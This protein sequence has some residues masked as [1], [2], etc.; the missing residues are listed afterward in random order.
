M[1]K[2]GLCPVSDNK[3]ILQGLVLRIKKKKALFAS[4]SFT[5]SC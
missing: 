5:G 1:L 3:L 2:L 4:A